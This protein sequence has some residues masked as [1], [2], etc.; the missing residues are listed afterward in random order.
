MQRKLTAELTL[1][2]I[3]CSPNVKKM[4]SPRHKYTAC[5]FCKECDLRWTRESESHNIYRGTCPHCRTDAIPDTVRISI[6]Y[7]CK[8]FLWF[9]KWNCIFFVCTDFRWLNIQSTRQIYMATIF[10]L[11]L[12]CWLLTGFLELFGFLFGLKCYKKCLYYGNCE[13]HQNNMKAYK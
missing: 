12:M 1:K 9:E 3:R 10:P 7:L 6:F 5:F 2:Q 8:V 13:L 4:D 11:M